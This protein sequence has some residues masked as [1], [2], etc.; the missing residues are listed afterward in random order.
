[1]VLSQRKIRV[2]AAIVAGLLSF[3][4][5]PGSAGALQDVR[6]KDRRPFKR[7]IRTRMPPSV[8]H[9]WIQDELKGA[10][11]ELLTGWQTFVVED[12]P[13]ADEYLVIARSQDKKWAFG[14]EKTDCEKPE[15]YETLIAQVKDGGSP[16]HVDMIIGIKKN[17]SFFRYQVNVYEPM[18]PFWKNPCYVWNLPP[19]S[20]KDLFYGKN[21]NM[22]VY[23]ARLRDQVYDM[24]SSDATSWRP[25]KKMKK[26]P[27]I[28][29]PGQ[30]LIGG[31]AELL[32]DEEKKLS[33]KEQERIL[34]QKK[35][36]KKG[37]E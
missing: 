5:M 10:A 15:N 32:T 12:E 35:K 16:V 19:G 34:K 2:G 29:G 11:P 26:I 25:P 13:D 24:V 6:T 4:F 7:V 14:I 27:A 37:K 30:E 33:V 21:F 36:D 18:Y 31:D 17:R 22:A 28:K 9:N 3:A 8:F 1:M 23:S 20:S